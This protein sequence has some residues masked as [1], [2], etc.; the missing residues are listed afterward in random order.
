MKKSIFT[1]FIAC[2]LTGCMSYQEYMTTGMNTYMGMHYRDLI[3]IWG[4]PTAVFGVDRQT[5]MIQY[6]KSSSFYM[7]GTPYSA[8]I[9]PV[10]DRTHIDFNGSDPQ[11]LTKSCIITFQITDVS[12]TGYRYEGDCTNVF[13]AGNPVY[14]ADRSYFSPAEIAR[15]LI[16][17]NSNQTPSSQLTQMLMSQ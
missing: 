8:D 17:T 14:N 16:L 13:P 4:I 12:V 2:L 3:N 6:Y 1:L 7:P 5:A 10:G 9:I 15:L 11:W